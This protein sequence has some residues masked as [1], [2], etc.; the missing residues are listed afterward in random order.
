MKFQSR[1]MKTSHWRNGSCR[2]I[3]TTL[4]H[5]LA[6]LLHLH[7]HHEKRDRYFCRLLMRTL[8]TECDVA[9]P[10][11]LL[12]DA[13]LLC[14]Y[15]ITQWEGQGLNETGLVAKAWEVFI[16]LCTCS[17]SC[18]LQEVNDGLWYGITVSCMKLCRFQ[19]FQI[20]FLP[21]QL[22]MCVCV[23]LLYRTYR[24]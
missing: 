23:C 18:W 11:C 14:S 9:V 8:W 17:L 13:S 24:M 2:P 20:L 10:Y 16:S 15:F 22:Y 4:D 6:L 3:V 21:F 7:H 12:Q 19:P 1:Y 5:P